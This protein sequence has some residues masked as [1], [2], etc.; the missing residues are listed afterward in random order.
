MNKAELR[1]IALIVKKLGWND[2]PA[3]VA[4]EAIQRMVNNDIAIS[5]DCCGFQDDPEDALLSIATQRTTDNIWL[6][7]FIDSYDTHHDE[8]L[9]HWALTYRPQ[10]E[11]WMKL[12]FS[13]EESCNMW[14]IPSK[15]W[16]WEHYQN[17]LLEQQIAYDETIVSLK[18]S[19]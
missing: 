16:E 12:G 13:F 3:A 1:A 9:K 11:A 17:S 7:L 6:R 19:Y 14:D 4:L 10:I 5:L 8:S 18:Y 2:M 15:E